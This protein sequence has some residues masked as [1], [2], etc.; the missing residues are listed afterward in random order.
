[1]DYSRI[2]KRYSYKELLYKLTLFVVTV[3]VI[4]YFFPRDEKF[5]FQF[6]EGKPWKYGELIASFDFPIYKSDLQIK[7]EQ[8]S[9]LSAFSPYYLLDK[10]T[11]K[12][13]LAKLEENYKSYLKKELP[14]G[15]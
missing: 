1:M 2:K 11:E 15:K 4:V 7:E 12:K 8:D 9:V 5:S 6:D 3:G 14:S 13:T 10:E